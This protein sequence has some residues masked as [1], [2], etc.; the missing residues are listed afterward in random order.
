MVSVESSSSIPGSAVPTLEP[1]NEDNSRASPA[2]TIEADDAGRRRRLAGSNSPEVV[3]V[4]SR[5]T[6]TSTGSSATAAKPNDT[7]P[8]YTAS[9]NGEKP[10][11]RMKVEVVVP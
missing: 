4:S 8:K 5:L 1:E 7:V 11:Q 6:S 3:V 2:S 9:Q 10:W